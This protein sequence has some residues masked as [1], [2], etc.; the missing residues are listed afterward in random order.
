MFRQKKLLSGQNLANS[1]RV[2]PGVILSFIMLLLVVQPA[3]AEY[4]DPG[5]VKVTTPFHK[6][7]IKSLPLGDYEYAVRWERIPV[8][9]AYISS[10]RKHNTY[11]VE[12]KIK[13]G[14]VIDIFY[15]LRH[16]SRSI[17]SAEDFRPMSFFMSQVENGR[18]KNRDI[19]F[20]KNGKIKTERVTQGE[21]QPTTEFKSNNQTLDPYTGSFLAR[22]IPLKTGAEESFDIFNGRHRFL[23]VFK[24]E[25]KETIQIGEKTYN[26]IPAS[27]KVTRLTET[28]PEKRLREARIW[29]TDDESRDI[30][31]VESE[32]WVGSVTAELEKFT[33]LADIEAAEAAKA[34][35]AKHATD[36]MI[37]PEQPAE[38]K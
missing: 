15:R 13:T 38:I 3:I 7:E 29:I 36:G 6:P 11:I 12:T 27:P 10:R 14:S 28:E 20:F 21:Q 30:V 37:T 26:T 5:G 34:A 23:I 32:V 8:A 24:I 31:K 18:K 1:L 4:I 17:F 22:A 9:T 33:S 16:K 35:M 2:I 19:T 25:P